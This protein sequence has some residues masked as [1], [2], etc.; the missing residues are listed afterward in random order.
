MSSNI[1][2]YSE[3]TNNILP[4]SVLVGGCF[5]LVHIGHVTFLKEAK[6]IAKNLII[7]LESDQF[8]V[9]RKK[10]NPVHSQLERATILAEL[11]CVD[12][13]IMLPYFSSHEDYKIMVQN[14]KPAFIAITQG[15]PLKENKKRFAD[16]VSGT[17]VEIPKI[18]P[19]S[20]TS[21]LTEDYF[22]E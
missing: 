4:E 5:D 14:I 19:I 17:L 3:L 15:D 8:I 12:L 10:R 22:T 1:I 2:A 20:T 18:L 9:T 6:K 13:V 21:I 11:R 7:V 16:M